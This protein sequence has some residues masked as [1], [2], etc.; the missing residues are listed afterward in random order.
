ME[1]HRDK[2]GM[3][4]SNLIS[5]REMIWNVLIPFFHYNTFRVFLDSSICCCQLGQTIIKKGCN[6]K[7]YL[8]SWV[9][10]TFTAAQVMSSFNAVLNKKCLLFVLTVLVFTDLQKTLK[11]VVGWMWHTKM[12]KHIMWLIF[13]YC[14][15]VK[16]ISVQGPCSLIWLQVSQTSKIMPYLP[17][18]VLV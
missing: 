14:R 3:C 2:P 7:Y 13:V 12:C 4:Q 9:E 1:T 16:L 8:F 15:A 10:M 18:N 5:R 11:H 6:S 17:V